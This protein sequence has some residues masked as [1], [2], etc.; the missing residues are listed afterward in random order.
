MQFVQFLHIVQWSRCLHGVDVY[1]I[2]TI[3]QCV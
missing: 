2:F 1:Y 3:V